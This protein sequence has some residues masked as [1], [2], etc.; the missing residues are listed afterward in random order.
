MLL[1]MTAIA[2]CNDAQFAIAKN[3]ESYNK[4]DFNIETLIEIF[5]TPDELAEF[6][7]SEFRK[8]CEEE[9]LVKGSINVA[10]SGGSTPRKSFQTLAEKFKEKIQWKKVNL[11]WVDERCVAPD[12]KQS[13]YGMTD[14]I[15][16]SKIPI[17]HPNIHRMRGEHH[18][19]EEAKRYSELL[20]VNLR[21]RNNFPVFDLILLGVGTDGHTA[22]IF[23]DQ[24]NLME[25]AD[26]AA[27]A[28]QPQTGQKRITLTGKVLNNGERVFFLITGDDKHKIVT[29]I[30]EKKNGYQKYPAAHIQPVDGILKW[31]MSIGDKIRN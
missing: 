9:I 25:S 1:M 21:Q 6:F 11:Y 26:I 31:N 14:E 18:P 10:L 20:K 22:S 4:T 2:N 23:P 28:V 16:L 17:P 12:D 13:N 27:V 24:M 3:F 19:I 5:E 29:D 8:I 7:S 15:L 30:L